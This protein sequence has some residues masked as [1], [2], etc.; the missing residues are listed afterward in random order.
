MLRRTDRILEDQH[1]GAIFDARSI[2]QKGFSA[3]C[4]SVRLYVAFFTNL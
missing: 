1:F 4:L 2:L 3:V